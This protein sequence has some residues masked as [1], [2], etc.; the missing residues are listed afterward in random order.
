MAIEAFDQTK[1]EAFV[2]RTLVDWG[3]LASA[4]LMLIGHELGLYDALA[5]AGPLS[6]TELARRTSTQERYVSDWLLN[7]AAGGVVEYD[8]LTQR[9][10]IPAEHA[11]VLPNLFAG[12]EALLSAVRAYPQVARAF[13][14]GGGVRWGEHAPELWPAIGRHFRPTYEQFL[15]QDW[16]P[17]LNGVAGK[18]NTRAVVADVGCGYGASSILLGQAFPNS[19]FFGFDNHQP[20][21][22][23]ARAAATREGL[24]ERVHFQA[25]DATA[26]PIP[27]AGYDL[28]AFFDAFHDMSN[29]V[30]VARHAREALAPHG[31]VLLVEPMAFE[32]VED[33]LHPLGRVNAAS[34]VLICATNALADGA[35]AL[36]TLA[37]E[38]QI[39]A[40]FEEAGFRSFR[41][42]AETPFNRVFEARP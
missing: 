18:L 25:S 39:R 41:R 4:P 9:Y 15:V 37:T 35:S 10:S 30:A 1:L 27:M 21:I 24:T 26:Y 28:I 42:V 11:V 16:I 29:P 38:A 14:N 40:T 34:S 5:E 33:N 2:G 23:A 36:G 12:Y 8:P 7:Q 17:A 31:S 3:G 20:S 6:A 32:R 19:I 22:N 13:K